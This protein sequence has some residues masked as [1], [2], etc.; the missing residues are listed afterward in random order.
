[1]I[2]RASEAVVNIQTDRIYRLRGR[3]FSDFAGQFFVDFFEEKDPDFVSYQCRSE[4]SGILIKADGAVL[5]NEHVLE[6]ADAIRVVLKDG[7][8]FPARAVG[9]NRKEDLALLRI[10][11]GG[12]FP[13]LSFGD[14]D[15]V[16]PGEEV[17]AIGTP[18]GY[19]QTVSKGI[20][21]AAHRKVFQGAEVILD[22]VIQTDA[23]AYPGSSGGPLLNAQGEV[24]G[25]VYRG[26]WRAVGINFAIP[27]NKIKSLLPGLQS[28]PDHYESRARFKQHF[29]FVPEDFKDE[30]GNQKVRLGEMDFASRAYAAGL[31]SGDLLLK[32]HDFY[33]SD[34]ETLLEKAA[35]I[36]PGTR[37]RLEIAKRTRAFFTYLEAG[38]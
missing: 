11:G 27:S 19:Q 34:A 3:G 33:V 26:D 25:L 21:S 12:E 4:G 32:F 6:N 38:A 29:G 24:V 30:D 14:S 36:G 22:D 37:V 31:R 17:I 28:S 7:R 5:T 1:M 15:T 20:V 10:E 9:K 23:S 35:A 16:Q 2:R 8:N 18:Y 13:V